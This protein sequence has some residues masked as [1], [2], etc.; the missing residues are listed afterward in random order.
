MG[1]PPGDRPTDGGGEDLDAQWAELTA[2]I[3]PLEAP[4]DDNVGEG[5]SDRDGDDAGVAIPGIDDRENT[6]LNVVSTGPRDYGLAFDQQDTGFVPP[7]P[8]PVITGASRHPLAWAGA[9]GGPLAI[10]AMLIVWPTAPPLAYFAAF[11]L[12][13]AGLATLWW[14][15]PHRKPD[16]GN[17][18]AV[19]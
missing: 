13:V 18:G 12:T 14:R 16:D 11:G 6:E 5:F 3:G 17:D 4:D 7:D 1:S 15:L 8:G 10:L 2:R 19:V 9:L